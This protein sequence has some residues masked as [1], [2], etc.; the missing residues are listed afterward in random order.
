MP[1]GAF[2]I[3]VDVQHAHTPAGWKSVSERGALLAVCEGPA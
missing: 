1:G 3:L 2:R